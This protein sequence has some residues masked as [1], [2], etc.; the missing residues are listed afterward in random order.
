[1]DHGITMSSQADPLSPA[2]WQVAE[3]ISDSPSEPSSHPD[4]P[5]VSDYDETLSGRWGI[6]LFSGP[7]SNL[8]EQVN[9]GINIGELL[10]MRTI[11][12]RKELPFKS[13]LY[14]KRLIIQETMDDGS[15]RHMVYC[16]H[17]QHSWGPYAARYTTTYTFICNIPIVK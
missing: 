1:M 4:S 12:C 8:R 10:N 3:T 9:L 15:G 13:Y 6:N 14:D 17:C 2:P 16:C 11:S 5:N 7:Q